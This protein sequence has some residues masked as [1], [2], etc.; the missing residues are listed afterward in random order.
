MTS[1]WTSVNVAPPS[2]ENAPE[3]LPL[4]KT[5]SLAPGSLRTSS[6][7]TSPAVVQGQTG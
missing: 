1:G 7:I 5:T 3:L 2:S 6:G 4:Q